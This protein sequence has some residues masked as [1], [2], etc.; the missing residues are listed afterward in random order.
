MRDVDVHSHSL[1]FLTSLGPAAT[2][3]IERRK[4]QR[5][6]SFIVWYLNSSYG[7]WFCDIVR[8][9]WWCGVFL[10]IGF[11]IQVMN[12]RHFKTVLSSHK[13]SNGEIYQD[14]QMPS[15]KYA[16]SCTTVVRGKSH[17]HIEEPWGMES[18]IKTAHDHDPS[19]NDLPNS[20]LSIRLPDSHIYVDT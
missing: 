10:R 13:K 5:P 12:L 6:K 20:E 1:Q 17:N 11:K 2:S 16:L 15:R 9:L 7:I 3:S 8:L 18:G 19:Q 4:R 14:S